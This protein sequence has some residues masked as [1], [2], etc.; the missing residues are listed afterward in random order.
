MCAAE[1]KIKRYAIATGTR[2]DW[3]LLKPLADTLSQRRETGIIASAMHLLDRHGHTIDEIRNDGYEPVA[4]VAAWGQPWEVTAMSISGH[5]KAL[6]DYD[7]DA[8]ILL[9]DRTEMLGAATASMMLG[10]PVVHIAG[11]TV[12]EGAFDDAIRHSITK[13]ATLHLPETEM[14]AKRIVRMGENPVNVVT[15]GALGV[16]NVLKTPLMSREELSASLNFNL[17]GDFIVATLH[18]AT[19]DSVP[20]IDRM[21]SFLEGMQSAMNLRPDLKVIL[22]YPNNDFDPASQISAMLEFEKRNEGRVLTIPSLGRVRYLSA[23]SLAAAV[24][25]NS[26][27]GIVEIPS[28]GTPVVDIGCRQAGRECSEA[29]IH[30]DADAQSVSEAILLSLSDQ[31][32]ATAAKKENPYFRENTPKQMADTIIAAENGVL[33]S[34][35]PKKKFYIP[36][37]ED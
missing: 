6:Q 2:A 24:V 9:G 12:S 28:T 15:C 18:P 16:Y 3:G 35:Y 27:S 14:C 22:T 37:N 17:D 26:S 11:G 20:P 4:T 10:I 25:G 7:P 32:R 36:G 23:A 19:L 1:S 13:M 8:L 33:S 30:T 29:V 21:L 5:A 34:K 31:A